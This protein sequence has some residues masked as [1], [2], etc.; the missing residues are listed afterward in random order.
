MSGIHQLRNLYAQNAKD[1]RAYYERIDAGEGAVFRGYRLTPD[2]HLRR[3]VIMQL[4]CNFRLEKAAVEA[5]FGI[6]F[7]DYFA[8]ALHRL[9][10]LEPDGL[11]KQSPETIT[12]EPTGRLLIRPIVASFDAYLNRNGEQRPVYSQSV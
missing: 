9:A 12:V 5:Q 1:L 10:A 7:D 2:D 3:H 8:S 11:V 4:M 6:D